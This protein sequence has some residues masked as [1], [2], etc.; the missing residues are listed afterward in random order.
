MKR[1]QTALTNAIGITG[2]LFAGY[3]LVRSIPDIRRYL[4]IST[5]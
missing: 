3:V 4:K 1:L 2:L 5:M